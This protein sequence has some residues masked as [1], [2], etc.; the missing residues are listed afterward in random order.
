MAGHGCFLRLSCFPDLSGLGMAYVRPVQP[1][2]ATP[3]PL[4]PLYC[5]Q[6]DL[7][8]LQLPDVPGLVKGVEDMQACLKDLAADLGWQVGVWCGAIEM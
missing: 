1:C 4:P 6:A 7:Q 2:T 8:A 3:V 5:P